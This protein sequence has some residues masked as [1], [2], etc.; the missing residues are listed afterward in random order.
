MRYAPS[1]RAVG[2]D[3][4]G[5]EAALRISEPSARKRAR[6]FADVQV[7]EQALV[8]AQAEAAREERE[9]RERGGK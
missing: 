2:L 7:M 3:Y 9:A 6:M 1:G 5:V 4:A 8:A